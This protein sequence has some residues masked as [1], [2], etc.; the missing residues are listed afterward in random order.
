MEIQINYYTLLDNKAMG[1]GNVI[2]QDQDLI[3]IKK[4]ID[5][6]MFFETSNSD[7]KI[8]FWAREDEVDFSQ[9][10]MET[11]CEEKINERNRYINGEFL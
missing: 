4:D 11:W 5:G 9:T 8:L 3:F 7:S 1:D 2:T 6:L 10:S